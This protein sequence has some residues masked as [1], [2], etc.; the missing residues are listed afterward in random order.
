MGVD[1][2]IPVEEALSVNNLANLQGLH[3]LVDLGGAVTEVGL[4]GE[5]VGLVAHSDIEVQVIPLGAGA[6]PVVEE[7]HVVAG[8]VLASGHHGEALEVHQ[9][10]L[11]G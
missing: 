6:V 1:A 11:A 9:L 4:H 3:G 10:V 2:L 7:G 5:G 8:V